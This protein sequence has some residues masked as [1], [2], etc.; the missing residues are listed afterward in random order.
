MI[1]QEKEALRQEILAWR[2][3]LTPEEKQRGAVAM[4]EALSALP[5]WQQADAVFVYYAT[6]RE[7]PTLPIIQMALDQGKVVALPRCLHQTHQ[8]A[9]LRYQ[10]EDTLLPGPMGLQEP[11]PERCPPVAA[12][13]ASLCVAPAL[14][15]DRH[16]M[17]LGYGGG[18]YDRFLAGFPGRSAVLVW[19]RWLVEALPAEAH[20]RPLDWVITP[21][22]S[23]ATAP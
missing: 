1:S 14:A 11:D 5:A 15:A 2:R 17:R 12:T 9:F 20:D 16:G 10:G 22:G 7:V 18:W 4:A 13:S 23:L 3:G 8:L 21:Q 19:D 6:P